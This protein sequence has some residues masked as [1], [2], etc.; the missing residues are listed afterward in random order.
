MSRKTPLL[1]GAALI[2]L[3]SAPMVA[4]AQTAP[5]SDRAAPDEAQGGEI[6][7][8]AQKRQE[9]LRDVPMS[10]SA[11]G[12]AELSTRGVTDT[13]DLAKIVP[14]FTY[15]ASGL[16]NPVYTIRGVGFFDYSLAASPAVTV[17]TDEAP[18]P[19]A[20]MTNHA[21]LD[22]Q[23]VEVLKGPQGTVFGQNSTGGAINFIAARPTSDFQAGIDGSFAR[24]NSLNFQGYISRPISETLGIRVSGRAESSDDWQKSFTR[25]DSIGKTE[26]FQARVLLEWKPS[27]GLSVT[28]NLN[29]WKDKSDPQ[30]GQLVAL[31]VPPGKE[32]NILPELAALP[33]SGPR[34]L[35][36]AD[37]DAGFPRRNNDLYQAVLRT[38][39]ELGSDITLTSLSSYVKARQR[40]NNDY[41]GEALHLTDLML[42]GFAKSFNQEVR[43][44]GKTG[45]LTWLLGGNLSRDRINDDETFVG[46]YNT[47]SPFFPGGPRVELLGNYAHQ[48]IDT[49]AVFGNVE[50]E[51]IDHLK[52]QA[53][54]RYTERKTRFSGCL[55]GDQA[56]STTFEVLQAGLKAGSSPVVPITPFSTC[57]SLNNNNPAANPFDPLPVNTTFKE[58]NVS[59]RAGASYQPSRDAL[60]YANVSKGYK[61]G[62]FPTLSGGF[63][64]Q[65]TP[66]KQESVLAYEAGLKL[67]AFD[68][69]VELTGAAFY[70]DYR[71]KQLRGKVGDP[72][73]GALDRLVN[74]PKSRLWGLELQANARPVSGWDLSA[75]AVYLNSKL[76]T[77]TE[78]FYTTSGDVP[79]I[80]DGN[81]YPFTPKFQ[82]LFDTQYRWPV[83]NNLDIFVG[84]SVTY[85]SKT[86]SSIGA[87]DL[88]DNPAYTLVDLRAGLAG[89]DNRWRVMVFGRN[90]TNEFYTTSVVHQYE[91]TLRFTGRPATYGINFTYEFD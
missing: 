16:S 23:R 72:I 27:P 44:S 71:N 57:M 90:V 69:K 43:L 14:G 13:A 22:L 7:V 54:A 55:F 29:G 18:L 38:D 48:K 51:V 70:Y 1:R 74:I 66:A 63:T 21:G 85:N 31:L 34:D 20:L 8:T 91:T 42:S 19:Y 73:F 24:F 59:W 79:K 41:D 47:D 77:G 82:L 6:I 78:L 36:S 50:Y 3:T 58:D 12:Q 52:I 4:A 80:V 15:S 26:F 33:T 39:Y 83:R 17:Y 25:D 53:G 86:S 45:R 11:V 5:S 46:K 28:L 88:Y 32:Q 49:N 64:S 40:E 68:G 56:L 89:N 75:D 61:A 65:Y 35:R 81:P 2:V 10:I 87:E 30:V 60:F 62:S 76:Q 9:R 37:W 67:G 84:G